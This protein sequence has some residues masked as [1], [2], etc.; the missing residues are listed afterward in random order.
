MVTAYY[1]PLLTFSQLFGSVATLPVTKEVYKI[2][3]V[4]CLPLNLYISFL[5]L[6]LFVRNARCQ[7][8]LNVT[9]MQAPVLRAMK[10][11]F[12]SNVK[13]R[14]TPQKQKKN[15][16]IPLFLTTASSQ[17]IFI[18]SLISPVTSEHAIPSLS[19]SCPQCVTTFPR[20]LIATPTCTPAPHPLISSPVFIQYLPFS[21]C[22]PAT[23]SIVPS[24]PF[25]FPFCLLCHFRLPVL[26]ACQL[27]N[28][29]FSQFCICLTCC[30]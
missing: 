21:H 18:Q 3:G 26:T 25:V 28:S 1:W 30:V 7:K 12:T 22:L 9:Q 24:Q 4:R 6:S 17:I 16:T 23:S 10:C 29:V 27:P 14:R 5:T 13:I 8:Q 2:I 19:S 11:G 20:Q 15:N